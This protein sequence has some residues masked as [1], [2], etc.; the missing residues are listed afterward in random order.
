M[1]K[2][3]NELNQDTDMNNTFKTTKT[4]GKQVTY[5]QYAQELC[6]LIVSRLNEGEI[7]WKH[8]AKKGASNFGL[9]MNAV[10]KTKYNGLNVLT[11][12]MVQQMNGYKTNLWVTYKQAES[13]G[14]NVRTGS[15]GTE[16]W[17]YKG[18]FVKFEED[19]KGQQTDKIKYSGNNFGIA[20][21]FNLD[22]VDNADKLY[23]TDDV[24]VEPTS[25]VQTL[26]DV[27]AFIS[28]LMVNVK[29]ERSNQPRAYYN[30]IGDNLHIP[31]KEVF[32]ST[33]SYYSTYLHEIGHWTGHTTRL[34]RIGSDYANRQTY[35]KEELVAEVFSAMVASSLGMDIEIDNHVAYCQ[36]WAKAI[37]IDKG[38]SIAW[39]MRKAME[40]FNYVYG[41]QVETTQAE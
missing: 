32:R 3:N 7:A 13:A 1:S 40:A 23:P 36:S 16:I 35:G 21:L 29:V 28:D 38:D 5:D 27:E 19:D 17:Q 34:N 10:S 2:R 8:F 15:K 20:T 37:S 14:A 18:R 9:P 24:V 33:E 4:K 31:N 25:E 22:Q 11:L 26:Q 30:P 12:S 6:N 41:I 39:S